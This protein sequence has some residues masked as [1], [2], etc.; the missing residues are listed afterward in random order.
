MQ[1]NLSHSCHLSSSLQT[2]PTTLP[3]RR[4]PPVEILPSLLYT[5]VSVVPH[6]AQSI[7]K[8]CGSCTYSS[9][10]LPIMSSAMKRLS[11]LA[12]HLVPLSSSPTAADNSAM[13]DSDQH[14]YHIHQLSPTFFLSRAA[15]I[16]PNVGSAQTLVPK[17]WALTKVS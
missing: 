17:T 15:S 10:R 1:S 14:S 4:H 13:K 2:P 12:A 7:S 16:E 5:T 11:T 6:S 9:A 3:R 8:R